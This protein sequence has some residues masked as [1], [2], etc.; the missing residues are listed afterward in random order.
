[1]SKKNIALISGGNSGEYQISIS[2]GKEVV[3]TIDNNKFN[4]YPIILRGKDWYFKTET[5]EHI[6]IDKTDFSLTLNGTKIL[7]DAVFDAIHGT[8]G[9]DGMLQGYLDMMS[10]P[11]TSCNHT[12]SAL[13]F[14]K[15]FC[16]MIVREVNVVNVAKSLLFTSDENPDFDNIISEI[17]L[18]CFVKPVR[19][20]SSVG[21]SKA[22][23]KEEL[24]LAMERAF[25]VDSEIMVE[26]FI[27]GRELTCGTSNLPQFPKTLPLAEIISKH[28][29]FDYETKY[30]GSLNQEVIPAPI[31]DELTQQIQKISELLYKK[32]R[33]SGIVRFDYIVTEKDE[34]YFLEVNTIPGMTGESIVPKMAQKAGFS[35]TDLYTLLIN[36]VLN[37]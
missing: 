26:Q 7:F 16:N 2:S 30:N 22:K 27:K 4:V 25:Q 15:G 35:T 3:K 11:Y 20:G 36:N 21:V 23:T 24:M 29:F 17:G 14:H 12:V 10:I 5:N 8:P 6:Q 37:K 9:E 1:M 19:S 34:I 28:E 32:L 33:C 13:T 18:P 31:S